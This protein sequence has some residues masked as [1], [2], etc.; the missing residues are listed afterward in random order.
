MGLLSCRTMRVNLRWND[1]F[2]NFF[3]LVFC[4]G[5]FGCASKESHN[6]E[7]TKITLNSPS[8]FEGFEELQFNDPV[9]TKNADPE[10]SILFSGRIRGEIDVCGCTV[11]PQGGLSRRIN[12]V[13]N[14]FGIKPENLL[15]V[16]PGNIYF[17]GPRGVQSKK[18]QDRARLIAKAQGPMQVAAINVSHLDLLAGVKF[19]KNIQKEFSL[20]LISTNLV[21]EKTGSPI[22]EIRKDI[23][24]LQTPIT[25]LGFSNPNESTNGIP[26]G[27]KILDPDTVLT[28]T[29]KSTPKQNLVI[30]L[31]DFDAGSIDLLAKKNLS[32][33]IIFIDS[34]EPREIPSIRHVGSSVH[35]RTRDGGEMWGWMR[36]HYRQN[37]TNRSLLSANA[38]RLMGHLWPFNADKFKSLEA[39]EKSEKTQLEFETLNTFLDSARTLLP[40]DVKN[41]TLF[42]YQN[43]GLTQSYDWTNEIT[44]EQ[45][46]LSGS[47]L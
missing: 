40:L 19:L 24:V 44:Q 18:A 43:V 37:T 46:K 45:K 3:A 12:F 16:E 15:V 34:R 39:A 27:V 6:P 26:P 38:V 28:E 32:H 23:K 20:P 9:S 14:Q 29:L 13:R 7:S 1:I 31:S 8:P 22:F 30:I 41:R 21:D 42:E 10:I 17:S 2:F 25:V 33:S 5:F 36:L 47:K 11:N 35:L 4:V